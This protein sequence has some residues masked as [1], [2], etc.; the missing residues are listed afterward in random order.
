M[1]FIKILNDGNQ[2]ISFKKQIKIKQT[3]IFFNNNLV[4]KL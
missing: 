3:Y 4:S 2:F 1:V